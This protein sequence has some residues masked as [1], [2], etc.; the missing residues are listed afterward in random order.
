MKRMRL[1]DVSDLWNRYC[2]LRYLLVGGWNMFF[3]YVAF[4][5]L[6]WCF[7]GT[8]AG[9]LFV[10]IASAILGITNSFVCHRTFTYRSRGSWWREYLRFYVVYGGQILFGTG[11]FLVL[12]TWLGWNG[13]VVEFAYSVVMTVVTYWIHKHFS[14]RV[15]SQREIVR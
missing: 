7:G 10:K 13:Y 14:F 9:D 6:Y 1:P 15:Q 5:A 4:A 11:V 8:L 2:V 3:G 12:S